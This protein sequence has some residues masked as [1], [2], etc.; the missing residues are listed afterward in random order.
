MKGSR[1][2]RPGPARSASSRQ[3]GEVRRM[4]QPVI[5]VLGAIVRRAH[6]PIGLLLVAYLLSGLTAVKADE[7]AIVLRFGRLVGD[8]RGEQIRQPGLLWAM[9][10]P[11]DEVVRVQINKLHEVDIDGLWPPPER[12]R[13]A[14]EEG[15]DGADGID[16]VV[17]GY[18]LTGDRNIY[19]VLL[20]VRYRVLDPVE[21]ALAQT[22]PHALLRDVVQATLVRAI[23]AWEIDDLL[24]G[25]REE[26]ATSAL[27]R[28]QATLDELGLGLELVAL[29]VLDFWL[30]RAVAPA[31]FE[32]QD[33]LAQARTTY[34]RAMGYREEQLPAAETERQQLIADAR[35]YRTELLASA[36]GR[37]RAFEDLLVEYR[38]APEVVR[39]RLWI[40]SVERALGKTTRKRFVQPPANEDYADDWR[41][42]IS[43]R[44]PT[45]Q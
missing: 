19:Q 9:P 8:G 5:E 31:F 15:A 34:W 42:T 35:I 2:P 13:F 25:R 20:R 22:D 16:P 11:I 1:A 41:I 4:A 43:T 6:W 17:E 33:A 37:A 45:A 28:A 36:R 38:A 26:L 18:A 29:E 21:Y 10:R 40:E 27:Q 30:P 44:R 12:L 7:V 14:P 23:G 39:E 3:V 32:V 24:T